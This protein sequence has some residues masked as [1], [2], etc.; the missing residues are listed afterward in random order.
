M[1]SMNSLLLNLLVQKM[2]QDD[3]SITT[4]QGKATL[5]RIILLTEKIWDNLALG[6]GDKMEEEDFKMEEEAFLKPIKSVRKRDPDYYY[7]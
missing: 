1:N 6:V 7:Y 3:K 2:K 4:R 5:N